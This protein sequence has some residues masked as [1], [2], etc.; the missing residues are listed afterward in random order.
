ML[1]LDNT[2]NK[3]WLDPQ[4]IERL[5]NFS[6]H[7]LIEQITGEKVCCR[8]SNELSKTQKQKECMLCFE[9]LQTIKNSLRNAIMM[10]QYLKEIL[11]TWF[12]KISES[13]ANILWIED[14]LQKYWN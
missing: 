5:K 4:R 3:G 7:E 10:D 9:R 13:L 1:N 11:E 14:P 6:C 12:Q 8:K 2:Q